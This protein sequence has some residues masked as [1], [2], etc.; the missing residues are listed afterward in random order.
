MLTKVYKDNI[1]PCCSGSIGAVVL[2]YLLI[3]I[4]KHV[5][6]AHQN[7]PNAYNNERTATSRTT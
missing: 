5:N 7:L 3:F 6:V 4:E 2:G 1:I